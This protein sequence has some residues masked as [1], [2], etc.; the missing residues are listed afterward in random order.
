MAW[1][2]LGATAP[3]GEMEGNPTSSVAGSPP[4]EEGVP[5]SAVSG[6]MS[7]WLTKQGSF[8]KSWKRRYFVLE[9]PIL[10]YYG[11]EEDA[12]REQSKPGDARK[13]KGEVRCDDVTLS[14]SI[15]MARTGRENCFGIFHKTRDA[16][17]V[18]AESKEEMMQWANAIR[19]E[20][21][22]GMIDFDQLRVLGEGAFGQVWLVNHRTTGVMLAMKVLSKEATQKEKAVE[23]TK[24]ERDILLRVRHPFVVQMHYAFQTAEKLFMVMDYV[25]GGDL[26]SHMSSSGRPRRFDEGTM[27]IWAAEI[28]MALGYLHEV[29]VAFRDLKPENILLDEQGHCHLTD[30]GLSKSIE[31]SNSRLHTFCGTPYYLAPELI[32]HGSSSRGKGKGYSKDIDWWAMGIL[33]YELLIGDPPF[34]GK[35]AQEV[36]KAIVNKPMQS[37]RCVSSAMCPSCSFGSA[38][39]GSDRARAV[40]QCLA[41]PLQRG[42]LRL[43]HALAGAQGGNSYWLR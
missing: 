24:V 21:S 17:F 33:C 29:G 34:R 35:T 25:N 12:T 19:H 26:Y 18:A 42:M 9:W 1:S 14:D 22:C 38:L 36:Y 32:T 30:F 6:N 28:C 16:F 31:T 2:G 3:R 41:E 4:A 13:P 10:R 15:S 40:V 5:P 37:V 11:S 7:G 43:Y 23:N 27:R 20:A 39:C 8:R